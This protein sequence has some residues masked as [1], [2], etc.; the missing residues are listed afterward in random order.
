MKI[1]GIANLKQWQ[2][3]HPVSG[4]KGRGAVVYWAPGTAAT[5]K[6]MS[7]MGRDDIPAEF[8]KA[9]QEKKNA[10]ATSST[11]KKSQPKQQR[12][13]SGKGTSGSDDF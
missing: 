13:L 2:T 9:A 8:S 1:S 4:H 3:K 7:K 10:A 6:S 12:T 11:K 5:A